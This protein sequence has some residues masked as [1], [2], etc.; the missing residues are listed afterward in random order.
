MAMKLAEWR[1][2]DFSG[3]SGGNVTRKATS[4]DHAPPG[5]PDGAALRGGWLGS[6]PAAERSLE[7]RQ[8]GCH[9]GEDTAGAGG[10]S[11]QSPG[12][13]AVPRD[14]PVVGRWTGQHL[15]RGGGFPW[16]SWLRFGPEP[17]R[18]PPCP[19]VQLGLPPPG[20]QRPRAAGKRGP[21]SLRRLRALFRGTRGRWRSCPGDLLHG[22]RTAAAKPAQP[23]PD[24]GSSVGLQTGLRRPSR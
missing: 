22:H 5:R 8:S 23:M 15:G 4:G 21:Y 18:S 12:Q 10:G 17:R 20:L 9:R 19:P 3:H 24:A 16:A 6:C 7:R 14:P 1:G 11:A 13:G 2:G